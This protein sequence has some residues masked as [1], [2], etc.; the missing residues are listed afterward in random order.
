LVQNGGYLPSRRHLPAQK[1]TNPLIFCPDCR[2]RRHISAPSND[3]GRLFVLYCSSSNNA[4]RQEGA[5]T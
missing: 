5:Q 4:G 3:P 1:A 2:Y